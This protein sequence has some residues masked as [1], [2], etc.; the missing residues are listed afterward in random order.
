MYSAGHATQ[1]FQTT[2]RLILISFTGLLVFG[3]LAALGN[4]IG[5]LMLASSGVHRLN[6]R[7]LKYLIA[8]GAGFMLAAIFIEI[9]PEAVSIWTAR[10][11]GESAARAVVAPLT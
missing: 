4:L 2:G 6:E 8:L 7:L 9:V 3:T 5:G 1:Q 11:T 10:Q